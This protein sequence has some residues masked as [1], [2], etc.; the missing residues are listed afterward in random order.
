MSF[1]FLCECV[2]KSF[3]ELNQDFNDIAL[4][5][6]EEELD[7]NVY[8]P[9][10]LA[11]AD[12]TEAGMTIPSSNLPLYLKDIYFITGIT[13]AYAYGWGATECIYSFP[14]FPVPSDILQETEL[15]IGCPGLT[16]DG[17]NL[18]DSQLCA[19]GETSSTEIVIINHYSLTQDRCHPNLLV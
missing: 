6:L 7:L 3:P 5:E 12:F 2:K 10:C 1:Y 16:N 18:D 14:D 19:M 9:V 13:P 17:L 11:R 4:L 15:T 8:T